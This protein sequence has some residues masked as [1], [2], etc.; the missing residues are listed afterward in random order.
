M[1]WP[2]SRRPN[3]RVKAPANVPF[4]N[5]T[6][7]RSFTASS[8]TNCCV[9]STNRWPCGPFSSLKFWACLLCL[10]LWPTIWLILWT[11]SFPFVTGWLHIDII[12]NDQ[13]SL[14]ICAAKSINYASTCSCRTMIGIDYCL[15]KRSTSTSVRLSSLP[16]Q[17]S[18][19]SFSVECIRKRSWPTPALSVI[20]YDVQCVRRH[21]VPVQVGVVHFH[22]LVCMHCTA[23]RKNCFRAKAISILNK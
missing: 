14:S 13:H 23:L 12:S 8:V 11:N 4:L 20:T 5:V 16:I 3:R 18:T 21:H 1:S 2:L 10:H 17:E 7:L 9:E 6:T 22:C 19:R 15:R